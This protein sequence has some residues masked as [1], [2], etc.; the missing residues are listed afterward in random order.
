MKAVVNSVTSR[1]PSPLG[2]VALLRKFDDLFAAT[3]FGA[4]VAYV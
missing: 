4:E 2:T 1:D 3:G